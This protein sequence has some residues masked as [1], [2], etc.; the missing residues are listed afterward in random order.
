MLSCFCLK[1]S[2]NWWW[3]YIKTINMFNITKHKLWKNFVCKKLSIF[4]TSRKIKCKKC[5]V[6]LIFIDCPGIEGCRSIQRFI[7]N[8]FSFWLSRGNRSRGPGDTSTARNET[9]LAVQIQ[10]L[11]TVYWIIFKL[12]NTSEIFIW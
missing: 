1:M 9:H 10:L 4:A 5:L 6:I 11:P 7:C 12:I 8:S 3:F 2:C